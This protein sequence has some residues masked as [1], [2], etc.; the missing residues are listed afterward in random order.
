MLDIADYGAYMLIIGVAEMLIQVASFGLLPVGQRYLPQL[1]TELSARHFYR[2]VLGLN[3]AQFLVLAA[4]TLILWRTW[5]AVTPYIGFSAEQSDVTLVGVWLFMWIPVFRFTVELLDALLE[6]GRAQI[7]RALMPVARLVGIGVLM[8][9]N[10]DL[11]LRNILLLDV[12]VTVACVVLA[13]FFLASSVATLGSPAGNGTVPYRDISRF[14]WHMATVGLLSA[15]ASPGA[16]RLALANALGVVESGLFAFLQS[17]TRLIS[18]YLPGTLLRGL[19]RPVMVARAFNA[20]GMSL[21]QAGTSLLLKT[22]LLIVAGASVVI[23][24]GGNELI[25]WISGDKF[26]NAGFT[27]LLMFVSL[28][29]TS[30]RTVIEMVM[31]ITGHTA[32]LRI[33]SFIWPLALFGVWL[34]APYGLNV[35]IVIMTLAAAI[36]NWVAMSVL[37]RSTQ[38]FNVDWKGLAVT[39]VA[40]ALGI[41]SGLALETETVYWV[42]A[43]AVGLLV[44]TAI[45]WR[46]DPYRLPELDVVQ[47]AA[48]KRAASIMQPFAGP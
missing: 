14:A 36:A 3:V 23:A 40:A 47:R 20:E 4:L 8:L 32:T 6:Q 21:V 38:G 27:L 34:L 7:A 42:A 43:A 45:L 2:F 39:L 16:M 11:D 18:R 33:T 24:V 37:I 19:V 44:Y 17:L 48:G 30:Q 22:N 9:M 12:G 10:I 1:L 31:Q 35:A 26:E 28:G 5:P 41:A 15:T 29:V 46:G 13:W 25:M